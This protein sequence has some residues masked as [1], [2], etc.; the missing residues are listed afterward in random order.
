MQL[1]SLRHMIAVPPAPTRS[2]PSSWDTSNLMPFYPRVRSRRASG[3]WIPGSP[4]QRRLGDMYG[5]HNCGPHF[6][7]VENVCAL[8]RTE[9]APASRHSSS[10]IVTAVTGQPAIRSNFVEQP[11]DAIRRNPLNSTYDWTREACWEQF[12]VDRYRRLLNSERDS[13][14]VVTY[15]CQCQYYLEAT[16]SNPG[17]QFRGPHDRYLQIRDSTQLRYRTWLS[18]G[19]LSHASSSWWNLTFKI[20]D[21]PS[22]PA[23]PRKH[24]LNALGLGA[25]LV[26]EHGG[27]KPSV[28]PISRS[29]SQINVHV[30]FEVD[31]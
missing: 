1:R 7:F 22:I 25:G 26:P 13:K 24:T 11:I 31:T 8:A 14:N 2:P 10:S 5:Q 12:S 9:I 21:P 6:S 29:A 17:N 4:A 19:L 18:E 20:V 28:L 15:Q 16:K 23:L 3:I 27:D 30:I